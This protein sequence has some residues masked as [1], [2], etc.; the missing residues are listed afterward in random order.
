MFQSAIKTPALPL[1][2]LIGIAWLPSAAEA[3]GGSPE[4]GSGHAGFHAGFHAGATVG[5]YASL[6]SRSRSV[7]SQRFTFRRGAPLDGARQ[8]FID[9]RERNLRLAN[10]GRYGRGTDDFGSH[11]G[12][13]GYGA[14]YARPQRFSPARFDDLRPYGAY[15]TSGVGYSN[16]AYAP[17]HLISIVGRRGLA[18]P[19]GMN[20]QAMRDGHR[21]HHDLTRSADDRSGAAHNGVR[22][23]SGQGDVS[24]ASVGSGINYSTTTVRMR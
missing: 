21:R 18:A 2:L 9:Q 23:F 8:N 12:G 15:G 3:R 19:A 4:F 22:V 24:T 10:S 17:P 6:G 16:A 11:N 5:R 7:Q 13:A 1:A 20:R 14:N